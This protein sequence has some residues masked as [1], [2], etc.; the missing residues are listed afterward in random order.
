MAV[1]PTDLCAADP[2]ITSHYQPISFN[3]NC[4]YDILT[5]TYVLNWDILKLSL[6]KE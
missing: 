4:L 3:V 1:L 2:T 6:L 5:D